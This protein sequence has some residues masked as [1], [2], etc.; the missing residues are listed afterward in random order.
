MRLAVT[1]TPAVGKTT[2]AAELRQSG[3]Q[4]VDIAALAREAGCIAGRDEADGSDV[5]DVE[6]LRRRVPADGGR[7]VAYEGHLSHLLGLEE[8][9]V[10]R[11]DPDVL[12]PRLQ[13]RGYPA[14]KVQ[15]NLEAEAMD[16]IL[17]EA[18][19]TSARVL[20][21][22]ATRRTAPETLQAFLDRTARPPSDEDREPV[23][24]TDRLPV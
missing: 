9:W 7:R 16:L 5:I 2:L 13:A 20:Q 6:R 8:V 10:L 21:V 11:C 18:Q 17:Q 1:G 12:R 23:D 14:A 19:D 3:W 22:D 4:V 24:W 15:E